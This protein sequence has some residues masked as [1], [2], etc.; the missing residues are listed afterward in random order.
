MSL[1][2][3]R[4]LVVLSAAASIST[5]QQKNGSLSVASVKPYEPKAGCFMRPQAA[6]NGRWSIPCTNVKY[7]VQRAYGLQDWE[8]AAVPDW[9]VTSYYS[10]AALFELTG[11]MDRAAEQTGLQQLLAERFGIK[12]HR[13]Q[14]Q[15]KILALIQNSNGVK[16]NRTGQL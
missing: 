9:A 14:R 13:E 5:A 16:F 3:K 15:L 12:A 8:I 4:I 2:M 7:L 11:T 10:V 1:S 6:A